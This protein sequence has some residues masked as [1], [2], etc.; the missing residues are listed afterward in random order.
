MRPRMNATTIAQGLKYRQCESE[1][2]DF[3]WR[4]RRGRCRRVGVDDLEAE[5]GGATRVSSRGSGQLH[6]VEV[7]GG[8]RYEVRRVVAGL[9]TARDRTDRSS[10]EAIRSA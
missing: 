10:P 9:A 6:V 5:S 8:E 7:A 3:L 2:L 1:G 4:W